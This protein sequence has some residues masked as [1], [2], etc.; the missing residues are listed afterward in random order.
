VRGADSGQSPAREARRFG[1]GRTVRAFFSL[2]GSHVFLGGLILFLVLLVVAVIV[3]DTSYA[4]PG[5]PDGLDTVESIYAVFGMLFFEH[6]FDLPRDWFSAA[7]FFLVPVVGIITLGQLFVRLG[8]T[9]LNREKWE[10]AKASTYSDHVI[11]CGLG[12]VGFRVC[13]WLLDLGEEVV[14]VDLDD[15]DSL[16]DQ[17]RAWGAPIIVADA[18]R[19]EILEQAGLHTASAIVPVTGDDLVNLGIATA[20]RGLRP[21]MRVVLR[22]FDDALAA[23][24]QTGFDIHRAYSTSALAAP[25]FAAAAVHAPVDYAFSYETEHDGE[26]SQALVTITKF[27]IVEG[28]KLAGYTVDR[29]ENEFG[30]NVIAVRSQGFEVHPPGDR[31]LNVGEGFVVSATPDGLDQLARYVPPTRE[32]R[33]YLQGRWP[34]LT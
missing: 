2:P 25:A 33:R 22:T 29:I 1:A 28:C 8:T 11:V 12:R 24:L 15:E 19:P 26:V 5:D 3:L 17:V 16:Y 4:M 7:L 13:R 30:V 9:V 32:M 10:M 34:I 6:V 18:R 20:A 27:T 31:V 23:N 14:V 21:D